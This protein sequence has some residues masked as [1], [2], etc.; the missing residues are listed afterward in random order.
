M[1]FTRVRPH[2]HPPVEPNDSATA[3][4]RRASLPGDPFPWA[5]DLSEPDPSAPADPSA[6]SDPIF[7]PDL[8]EVD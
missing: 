1:S 4:P 3:S 8:G 7:P 5:P 2:H 6:E